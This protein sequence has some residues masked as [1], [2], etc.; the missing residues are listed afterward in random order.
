MSGD[1]ALPRDVRSNVTAVPLQNVVMNYI[2]PP[3]IPTRWWLPLRLLQRSIPLI[4]T[5][6]PISAF[7][8]EGLFWVLTAMLTL[9]IM[10]LAGWSVASTRVAGWRKAVVRARN[11]YLGFAIAVSALTGAV[12]PVLRS[13][14]LSPTRTLV[15]AFLLYVLML[16]GE[17]MMTGQAGKPVRP[18]PLP[19]TDTAVEP[20]RLFEGESSAAPRLIDIATV[21]AVVLATRWPQR[22]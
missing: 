20:E 18:T 19:G 17:K 8:N 9:G 13:E 14:P 11:V 22:R 21:I 15:V 16:L 7:V 12:V 4:T 10:V 3:L 6:L 2:D 1:A 5:L